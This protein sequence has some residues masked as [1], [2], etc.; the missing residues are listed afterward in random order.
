MSRRVGK[1]PS[2]L[3]T[4]L[5]RPSQSYSF[6]QVDRKDYYSSK[7]EM[8]RVALQGEVESLGGQAPFEYKDT[9]SEAARLRS[10]ASIPHSEVKHQNRLLEE[11]LHSKRHSRSLSLPQVIVTEEPDSEPNS[12]EDSDSDNDI[13]YT[14]N[15]SPRTSFASTVTI[16]RTTLP[17]ASPPLQPLNASSLIRPTRHEGRSTCSISSTSADSASVD[18]HS[19]FSYDSLSGSTGITTPEP[20]IYSSSRG[21]GKEKANNREMSMNGVGEDWAKDVRWLVPPPLTTS[22]SSSTSKRKASRNA[23]TISRVSQLRSSDLNKVYQATMAAVIEEDEGTNSRPDPPPRTRTASNTTSPKRCTSKRASTTSAFPAKPHLMRRKSRSLEDLA[24]FQAEDEVSSSTSTPSHSH[25]APFSHNSSLPSYGTPG[26][27]SLTLPRAPPPSSG[28]LE[29]SKVGKVDL[30]RSGLAQTTMASVE[31]TRG[32]SSLGPSKR[33]SWLS[34]D[35]DS[36]KGKGRAESA[37]SFTSYRKPPTH[38]P[39]DHVLVQIWAVGIDGV[40]ASICGISSGCEDHSEYEKRMAS[41][42]G[43]NT[44]IKRSWSLRRNRSAP[45]DVITSPSKPKQPEVGFVPGRSFVGRVMEVG[46]EDDGLRIIKKGEWVV[47]LL[48]V[49]K[50]GALQEF[51]VVDRHRL[52]PIPHPALPPSALV[53]PISTPPPRPSSSSNSSSK[54]DHKPHD[55]RYPVYTPTPTPLS[56][57]NPRSI[58]KTQLTLEELALLPA[59]GLQA[60]RAVRTFFNGAGRGNK[61]KG[62]ILV[63]RGHDGVGAMAT[64]MLVRR[65][66]GVCVHASLQYGLDERQEEEEMGAIQERVK[67]WGADEVIFDDSVV[68]AIQQLI[69]EKEVFDGILDTVGGKEVWEVGKKLLSVTGSVCLNNTVKQFTTLFGDFPMRPIPSAS[70]HFKASLRCMK[71]GDG[72]GSSRVVYTWVS[73]D[74]DVD[75]EG[76][77]VSVGIGRVLAECTSA[78][79]LR[80][81]VGG[82]ERTVTFERADG[83]FRGTGRLAGGGTVVVRVVL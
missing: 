24:T 70:D 46:D 61:A 12:D 50:C 71:G 22:S 30:T 4:L 11:Q 65:G 1:S 10:T 67:S 57:D 56:P 38:V 54:S 69:E 29:S 82:S 45:T 73:I 74:Q 16:T 34:K 13:F 51:I 48:D 7:D 52:H 72:S 43:H 28:F 40:D 55:S 25:A 59:C 39:D 77:D 36:G 26:Y 80:P 27:T 20:S 62:K 53:D 58:S 41:E 81:Y 19:V 21:K 60:Y 42:G 44:R 5:N 76:G 3:Q 14:P 37:F 31:V 47:G 68:E 6:P 15:T 75:F 9:V 17:P 66:W 33:F 18:G 23:Q 8:M 49:R 78:G 63:L 64:Q 35:K 83:V 32:L 79:E 2:L